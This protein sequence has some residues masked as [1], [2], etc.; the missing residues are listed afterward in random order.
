MWAFENW[1]R[2]IWNWC[3]C[4]RMW[5]FEDRGRQYFCSKTILINQKHSM[6]RT[7][8][9]LRKIVCHFHITNILI[10]CSVDLTT[11]PDGACVLLE[12]N[13]WRSGRHRYFK[14]KMNF[15]GSVSLKSSSD[16]CSDGP[17]RWCVCYWIDQLSLDAIL[18]IFVL[19]ETNDEWEML[20][21]IRE[22]LL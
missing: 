4:P 22:I 1:D 11:R 18:D 16:V 20:K 19:L 17:I 8:W 12:Y 6:K 10:E 9:I 3:L 2:L 7:I 14:I 21:R 13:L 5:T 15:A